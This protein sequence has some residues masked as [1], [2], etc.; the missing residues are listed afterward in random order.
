MYSKRSLVL[1]AATIVLLAGARAGENHDQR[2][3]EYGLNE[4]QTELDAQLAG[5]HSTL[6]QGTPTRPST[7]YGYPH[8]PT[9]KHRHRI[10]R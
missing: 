9:A 6:I 10:N 7:P 1:F 3:G 5:S 4:H 8:R 2:G